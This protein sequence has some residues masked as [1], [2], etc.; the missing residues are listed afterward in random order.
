MSLEETL[1]EVWRQDFAENAKTVVLGSERYPFLRTSKQKLRQV[2]FKPNGQA[3]I[4][5]D[6]RI[7]SDLTHK[8]GR[9]PLSLVAR[10]LREEFRR[11]HAFNSGDEHEFAD[12]SR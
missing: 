8:D 12:A 3:I 6:C 11:S 10:S 9:R 4:T 5:V 1:I 7:A 2:D